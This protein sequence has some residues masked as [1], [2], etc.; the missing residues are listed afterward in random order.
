MRARIVQEIHS[1]G[2]DNEGVGGIE[3]ARDTPITTLSDASTVKRFTRPCTWM[4]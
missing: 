1:A 2:R 4:L 3:P